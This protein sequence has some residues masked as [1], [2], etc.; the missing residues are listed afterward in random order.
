MKLKQGLDAFLGS[1]RAVVPRTEAV[2]FIRRY[3]GRTRAVSHYRTYGRGYV[4]VRKLLDAIGL[5][6]GKDYEIVRSE[7]D[8]DTVQIRWTQSR[9]TQA[10]MTAL[11]GVDP[12]KINALAGLVAAQRTA[13][14]IRASGVLEAFPVGEDEI[15][16]DA[17]ERF[18]IDFGKSIAVLMDAAQQYYDRNDT[19]GLDCADGLAD[20]LDYGSSVHSVVGPEVLEL[21]IQFN[22][23]A[24][25]TLR[26]EFP[27]LPKRM[28]FAHSFNAIRCLHR[29]LRKGE[30]LIGYG[31]VMSTIT[32]DV[33]R[34]ERTR[35]PMIGYLGT[36]STKDTGAGIGAS[37]LFIRTDAPISDADA[38]AWISEDYPRFWKYVSRLYELCLAGGNLVCT[39]L[40]QSRVAM[41]NG[42]GDASPD[43]KLT[44]DGMMYL[45]EAFGNEGVDHNLTPVAAIGMIIARKAFAN[46]GDAAASAKEE[47]PPLAVIHRPPAGLAATMFRSTHVDADDEPGEWFAIA[48]GLA[49]GGKSPYD[50]GGSDRYRNLE[51]FRKDIASMRG[52]KSGGTCSFVPANVGICTAPGGDYTA[53]SAFYGSILVAI[54]SRVDEPE[55]SAPPGS[56]ASGAEVPVIDSVYSGVTNGKSPSMDGE[57]TAFPELGGTTVKAIVE[58]KYL[59]EA[60]K[61]FTEAVKAFVDSDTQFTVPAGGAKKRWIVV[62]T[63]VNGPKF[64][65][66]VKDPDA[67]VNDLAS[68]FLRCMVMRNTNPL[69]CYT[70]ED[71]NGRFSLSGADLLE[72][73][74]RKSA[75][76]YSCKYADIRVG[77]TYKDLFG[78]EDY[79]RFSETY[80]KAGT[81][82]IGVMFA[83]DESDRLHFVF[84]LEGDY[85]TWAS[86][87]WRLAAGLPVHPAWLMRKYLPEG[88]G[89][90]RIDA[91]TVYV[92]DSCVRSTTTM[93]LA[94]SVIMENTG[95]AERAAIRNEPTF[96]PAVL[97]PR[98]TS[99]AQ[100]YVSRE[101]YLEHA[102]DIWA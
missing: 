24:Y 16:A 7:F 35:N 87:A 59:P 77:G 22:G 40:P 86:A 75:Y 54:R 52:G 37:A 93:N 81:K 2:Q 79:L 32:G 68:S 6:E 98:A 91:R 34:G 45:R 1:V 84:S 33:I 69:C 50:V 67:F 99:A 63:N 74:V 66:Q 28:L 83:L 48:H 90:E 65:K 41:A 27:T 80:V 64:L 25:A 82:G 53:A 20:L 72:Q 49:Y 70:D 39:V 21:L 5:S 102:L 95:L 76:G 101:T 42:R 29:Y 88:T 43:G 31:M 60:K 47:I 58:G 85:A 11:R 61:M 4:A 26:K 13:E 23:D 18:G 10:L 51:R 96:G 94:F 12:A 44:P 9:M 17:S 15:E 62:A 55:R 57:P 100:R 36:T 97:Q 92:A 3:S 73:A 14:D 8:K 89:C 46:C 19:E 78:R 38:L 56:R 30:K 71:R